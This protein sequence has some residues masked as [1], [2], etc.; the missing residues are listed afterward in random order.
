[1]GYSRQSKSF[2]FFTNNLNKPLTGQDSA[3]LRMRTMHYEAEE[4]TNDLLNLYM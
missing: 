1:M 3:Q 4:K 2:A